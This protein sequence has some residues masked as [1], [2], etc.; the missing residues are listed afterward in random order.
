M[1]VPLRSPLHYP[2]LHP[3]H[4]GTSVPSAERESSSYL[5]H[6]ATLIP[7]RGDPIQNGAV[8]VSDGKVEWVGPFAN[9]PSKYHS[10]RVINV[11]VLMPGLWDCHCHYQAFDVLQGLD[12]VS[13]LPGTNALTGAITVEDLRVTLMSG[14]TSIRELGGNAGD[15]RP[16]IERG[17][18]IGPN[19]YSSHTALSITGG[20]GDDHMLPIQSVREAMDRGFPVALCDG[21]DECLKTVRLQI[22]RGA[23]VIKVCSTGGVLSLND[24]PEDSQFSDAELKAIV[25]EAGR[26]GRAVAAHAIGKAG[27]MAALRAGVHSIEHGM[28]LDEEVAELM[29][30][31]GAY[32]VATQH[33]VRTL[34]AH[35]L[36]TLPEPSRA[37]LLNILDL[38]KSS[39]KLAVKSGVKIALGTDMLSS[40]RKSK[41]SHGNN[42]HEL[43]WAVEAGMTPLEAIESATANGPETLGRLAPLSGQIKEGYDA[44]L[45]AVSSS[46]LHDISILAD[47]EN[48]THVWKGGKLYKGGN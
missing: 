25:E 39:Y 13:Y 23:K 11:P 42:G 31:K 9:R 6:A 32:L 45:I 18:L 3:A 5:I 44:D 21:V 19:V 14:Y 40:D 28:Y 41:L 15:L 8:A 12:T 30:E 43:R 7:G 26:S 38:S 33:I 37:K 47:P 48:I 27:I 16:G 46:P 17:L 36:D 1:R 4:T 10:I 24:N 20:H 22:R 29:K 35:Y 34:A 2:S